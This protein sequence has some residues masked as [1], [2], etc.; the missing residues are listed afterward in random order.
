MKYILPFFLFFTIGTTSALAQAPPPALVRTAPISQREITENKG[1]LGLLYYERVSNISSEVTG[2]VNEITV[3]TGDKVN[4]G[5]ILVHLNTELLEKEI[6]LAKTRVKQL[7]ARIR[8]A[9]NNFDRLQRLLKQKVTS[10]QKFEDAEF[11]VLD[12][13]L[14]KQAATETLAK[15]QL[16][17][18]KS[19]ITAPFSGII[20]KKQVDQG[21]WVSLGK[22]LLTLAS[23]DELFVRVPVNEKMIRFIKPGEKLPVI[24]TAYEQELT[25]ILQDIAPQADARTKNIF[26]K[27]HIPAQPMIAENMSATVFVPTS[28]KKTLSMIP[29]DALIKFKGKDFVY[30]VKEGKASI[31]PVNIVTRLDNEVGADNPYFVPGMPVVIEGNER[32][33]PD[34]A[35]TISGK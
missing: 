28:E 29:R 12:A 34:Q 14:E 27:V 19:T 1:F 26:L 20:L 10:A 9:K 17:K 31:L 32:L 33:R 2:L 18:K 21:D 30:T 11:N 23:C 5:D 4:K 7:Q 6:M 25:G 3:R 22:G 16:E 8:H 13:Q 24:L 35:V 15:L